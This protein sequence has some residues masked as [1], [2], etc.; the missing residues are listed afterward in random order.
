MRH[1]H[2]QIIRIF[3]EIFSSSYFLN[4]YL[5]RGRKTECVV[6]SFWG[7]HGQQFKF[8]NKGEF[9]EFTPEEDGPPKIVKKSKGH[10]TLVRQILSELLIQ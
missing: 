4:G 8:I 3:R 1:Q 5:L 10:T 6:F 7:K 2:V 9:Y